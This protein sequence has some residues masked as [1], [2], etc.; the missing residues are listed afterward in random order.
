MA[1]VTVTAPAAGTKTMGVVPVTAVV[2]V[3]VRGVLL[4]VARAFDE[5]PTD[6]PFRLIDVIVVPLGIPAPV[7]SMPT[8]SPTV[9]ARPVTI[10]LLRAMVASLL[11]LSLNCHAVPPFLMPDST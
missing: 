5:S 11:E 3:N 1:A 9:E 6:V 10:G 2:A 4:I 8:E 7:T